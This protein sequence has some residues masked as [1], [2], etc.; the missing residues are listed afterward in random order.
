M[1]GEKSSTVIDDE[2]LKDF[3]ENIRE[4]GVEAG[5]RDL[6]SLWMQWRVSIGRWKKAGKPIRSDAEIETILATCKACDEYDTRLGLPYCKVCG[7]NLKTPKIGSLSKIRM[8][9]EKC[10]K[11]KWE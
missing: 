10:P 1:C 6:R 3:G 5:E 2:I 11:G 4:L 9:T 8:A 7:C